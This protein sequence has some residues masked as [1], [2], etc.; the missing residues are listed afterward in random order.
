MLLASTLF[1]FH[2]VHD[3][4][5]SCPHPSREEGDRLGQGMLVP[6]KAG[7][8]AVLVTFITLW[9]EMSSLERKARN[10]SPHLG[11]RCVPH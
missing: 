11:F 5:P 7:E 10:H 6:I 3:G 1:S 4:T 9:L 8:E 2:V